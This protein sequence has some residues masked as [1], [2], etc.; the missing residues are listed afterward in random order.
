LNTALVLD[1]ISV[2]LI[3]KV[4]E[5]LTGLLDTTDIV[6]KSP[7][8][9][10]ADKICIYV[11]HLNRN[12]HFINEPLARVSAGQYRKQLLVIDASVVIFSTFSD[13]Q[14]EMNY[15]ENVADKLFR[16]P[17]VT[18]T[19]GSLRNIVKMIPKTMGLDELNKFWSM[20]SGKSQALAHFYQLSPIFVFPKA[21]LLEGSPEVRPIAGNSAVPNIILNTEIITDLEE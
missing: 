10:P 17:S 5:A 7:Q 2:A 4:A 15:M 8:Y 14:H 9:A 16:D 18:Q 19:N 21:D 13:T 20:F 6:V 1:A 3:A 11:Y 12:S